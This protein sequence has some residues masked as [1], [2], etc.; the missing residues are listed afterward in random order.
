MELSAARRRIG[1]AALALMIFACLVGVPATAFGQAAV[2]GVVDDLTGAA[3]PGV[4]V[5]A[6]S[7]ALIEKVPQPSAGSSTHRR[8]AAGALHGDLQPRRLEPLGALSHR[9]DGLVHGDID[10]RLGSLR[11]PTP[12]PSPAG[13][14]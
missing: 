14:R 5:E 3:L 7:P 10:A 12:S 6:R 9:A 11:S 4:V 13:S 8:S 2:A 1:R